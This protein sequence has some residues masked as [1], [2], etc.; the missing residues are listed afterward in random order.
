MTPI[1]IDIAGEV[2]MTALGTDIAAVLEKG[3]RIGLVGDLGAGKTTLARAVIRALAGDP[4][5]EVPSPT[6]T[7]VQPYEGRVPV[8][9]VDLYRVADPA[10]AEELGLGEDDAAE[11]IEWPKERLPVTLAIDFGEGGDTESRRITLTA[12]AAFAERF[13][14]RLA[15]RGFLAAA[16][17][18]EAERIP[19][20][21]DA[22]TRHYERLFR[23]EESAVLMNAPAFTPEPDSYPA[24]ARLANGNN[25]AFLAIGAL[26]ASRGFSTPRVL[27]ADA[28]GG[29]ILLEDLGN[30]TIAERGSPVAERYR[31][32][33][34]V[35]AA[36]HQT[37]PPSPIPGPQGPHTAPRYDETLGL[38]EVG[39]FPEWFQR[40]PETE[41]Y[42]ALWRTV[43]EGLWRGDDH[44]ALRDYHS[45]NCLWLPE[46]EGI[47]KI[48]IIDYQ[49]AMVAPSAFDVVSLAQDAR[50]AVP[51]ALEGELVERYLAARP[52][53]DVEK[54]RETY[55][56]I[57]A[58]RA[59]RIAGVFRRLNDRDGKPQYLGYIPHV[60]AALKRNLVATPALAPLAEWFGRNTTI[61]DDR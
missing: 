48:G 8:R 55:H 3:D 7:I 54:W 17:W 44:L 28:A 52:G 37:A 27:A 58:Q 31:L 30:T 26:L 15:L 18:G 12:P 20:K 49:D 61:M 36:F 39:L 5:L 19:L 6:F 57:G 45:P 13:E 21:Q 35:I 24:R 38:L 50:I 22:S 33:V 41:E 53:L 16:G 60:L 40:A 2:A 9:H 42:R 29:F 10:E 56:I 59:T 11:L 25:N 23:E 4:A 14:R 43:L 32:A 51:P 1:V 46:R 47:A 34:D